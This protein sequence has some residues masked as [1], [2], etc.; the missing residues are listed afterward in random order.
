MD[1][2]PAA[3][4]DLVSLIAHRLTN[5]NI[6]G[7]WAGGGTRYAVIDDLLPDEIARAIYEGFPND[8]AGFDVRKTFRESKRTTYDLDRFPVLKTAAYALQDKSIVD[9][10]GRAISV[11]DL[12]ADPSLY[13]GGPSIMLQGDFLNPH[14]DNSHD[15][16]KRRYRRLNLL[17]YVTPNW[18]IEDGGNL[19]LWDT[20]VR[21]AVSIPALFN[22][23]VLMETSRTSWHSVSPI[24]A[25]CERCCVSSYY[26]SESSPDGSDYYH[27]TSFNGRPG[28]TMNRFIAPIDNASRVLAR[29]IFDLRRRSDTGYRG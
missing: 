25:D 28:Q 21:K 23:L 10:I 3:P 1:T 9:L 5:C 18:R 26:F 19:E 13:A 11:P 6:R 29:Q 16:T 12:E 24:I 8:G 27:V 15:A 2:H 14:I 22:R 20:S 17:Y 4:A 7:Q